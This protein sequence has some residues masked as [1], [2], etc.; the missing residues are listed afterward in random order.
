MLEASRRQHERQVQLS[1]TAL[2]AARGA[3][4][5]LDQA[6]L[7]ATAGRMLA[8]IAPALVRAQLLAAT[9][10]VA[11]VA[12]ALAEQGLDLEQLGEVVPEALAGIASDGR[13]LETLLTVPLRTVEHLTGRGVPASRAMGSGLAQLERIVVTQ[14]AD[15]ARVAAGVGVA[16]RRRAGW[17]RQINPPACSRCIVLMDRVY[18]WNAGF[19]R[20]PQCQ[21]IHV[22]SD[23]MTAAQ[24]REFSSR[25]Y[26]DSLSEAEQDRI[27]GKAGAQAIRDGA[28]VAQVVNARRGMRTASVF[29]HDVQITLEGTTRRGLAGARLAKATGRTQRT[30]EELATRI[31]R[32]GPELRRVHRERA[33]VPRLMPEEIYRMADDR[34]HAIRLLHRNGYIH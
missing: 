33:G 29:G 12:A 3:W 6:A 16:V 26:F 28:S 10:G 19:Q 24:L 5:L 8:R 23:N 21:C 15:A 17:V 25:S 31:T 4:R 2:T 27:F 18:R 22:P 1:A 13:P 14:V 34:E 32:T 20:H 11:Y 7:D 9:A 30:A